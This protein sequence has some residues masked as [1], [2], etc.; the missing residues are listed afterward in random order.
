MCTYHW[1]KAFQRRGEKRYSCCNGEATSEGCS[2]SKYHISDTISAENLKGGFVR[3]MAK[4]P[5]ADGNYGVY[6]LDCEM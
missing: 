1:G 2:V 3:T 5:P 6:A 4:S